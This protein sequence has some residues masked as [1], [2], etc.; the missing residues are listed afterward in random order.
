V[1]ELVRFLQHVETGR[2]CWEWRGHRLQS[3]YGTASDSRGTEP[4]HRRS[5][6]LFVGPIGAGLEI[7]HLCR[8]RG[9]VRPDHL[10]LVTH[11]EN[12][13]RGQGVSAEN[14]RKSV[15]VNGHELNF[16]NTYIRKNGNRDCR[17]CKKL[18]ERQRRIR[19]QT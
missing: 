19:A 7:D 12:L 3:G 16:A 13:L 14:A 2:G 5:Y 15:C 18:R 17:V 1:N 11:R 4:A 10:E 9:C 6:R 8:N